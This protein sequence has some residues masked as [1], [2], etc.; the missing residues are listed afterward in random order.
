LTYCMLIGVVNGRHDLGKRQAGVD[1]TRAAVLA[2][3]RELVSASG[4]TSLSVGA[5]ARRAGVS[6]LTI[7][8][9]FGS[10]SGLLRAVAGEAHGRAVPA[11]SNGTAYPREELRERIVAACSSWASDPALFRA[12][13]AGDPAT[14]KDRGLAERLAAADQLRPG[15]SL[16]EAE[17]VIGALTSFAVFDRLHQDGRRS[18]GGVAEILMRLAGAI[19]TP[20]P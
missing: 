10:R 19:L 18:T 3:A 2:A 20:T 1:R 11:A 12:L 15:C 9:R 6:R 7:Y 5:V 17:D 16:K 14:Q 8:N 4:G 13:P